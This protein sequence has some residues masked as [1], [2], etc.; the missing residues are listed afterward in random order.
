[1]GRE[2]IDLFDGWAA[3]YDQTVSGEDVE[4]KEVFADYDGILDAVVDHTKG[5]NVMEFGVGTGNLTKKLI[6]RG[7]SVIGIEPSSEM[8]KIAQI[9]VPDAKVYDGDFIEFPKPEVQ[10]DSIVSSYAFH[11]LTDE[12]KEMAISKYSHLLKKGARI[13]FADT[14]F[15][16]QASKR[17]AIETAIASH[18]NNLADDLSAEYYTDIP[19]LQRICKK[20]DFEVLFEQKNKYVWVMVAEKK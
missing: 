7:H 3:S 10:V 4:Y 13:V 5:P 20:Y 17:R 19:T 8:L 2:F 14:V 9:K 15:E 16:T 18:Y 6:N 1:M 11:H 12:E